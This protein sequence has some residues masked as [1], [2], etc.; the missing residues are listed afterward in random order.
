MHDSGKITILV[1][2]DAPAVEYS[3]PHLHLWWSSPV[4]CVIVGVML[5]QIF[6]WSGLFGIWLLVSF[7]PIQLFAA[8]RMSTLRKQTSKVSDRRQ[9]LLQQVM[10][11]LRTI[12][13]KAWERVF[14]GDLERLRGDELGWLWR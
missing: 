3:I 11:G 1:S 12:K 8:R 14:E 7:L 4:Q 9:G 2:R 13:F 5:F 10:H 6:G